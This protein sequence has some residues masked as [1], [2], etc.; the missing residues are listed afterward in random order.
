MVGA[1]GAVV[2]VVLGPEPVL[3]VDPDDDGGA[4]VVVVPPVADAAVVV[5]VGG[6][7]GATNGTVSACMV[8]RLVDGVADRPVQ[9][10]AAVQLWR[11][12]VAGVPLNG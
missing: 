3:P 9:L 5:V 10:R 12:A 11:A 1:A 4:V 7:V 8:V 6:A 2:V